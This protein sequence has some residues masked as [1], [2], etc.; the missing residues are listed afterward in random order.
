MHHFIPVKSDQKDQKGILDADKDR[1]PVN[2]KWIPRPK[3]IRKPDRRR[4]QFQ[5]LCHQTEPTDTLIKD[6]F[7]E[8]GQFDEGGT[9]DDG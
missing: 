7:E 5:H 2:H 1:L 6:D 3:I 8:L 4:H 9:G